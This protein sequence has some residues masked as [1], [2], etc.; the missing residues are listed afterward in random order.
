MQRVDSCGFVAS[1]IGHRNTIILAVLLA[2]TPD[3]VTVDRLIDATVR[4]GGK[5]HLAK[6]Q[7]LRPDQFHRIFPRWP[8]LLEVKKRLD[9]EGMFTSDLA[10]R[11][12]IDPDRG[13]DDPAGGMTRPSR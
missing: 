11:V 13:C 1:A 3:D 2:A 9:P 8:E 7:V 12:G 5:V 10:R 4:Y 6:D